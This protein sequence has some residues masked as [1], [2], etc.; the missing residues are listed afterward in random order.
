ML[1]I[2]LL[3]NGTEIFPAMFDAVDRAV[4][5]VVLEMYIYADDKT[6]REFRGRLVNAARRGVRVMV[7]VDAF[8]LYT[9]AIDK[10]TRVRIELQ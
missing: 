2:R 6:G 9:L 3:K 10:D 4:S 5:C 8:D 7:L 1:S